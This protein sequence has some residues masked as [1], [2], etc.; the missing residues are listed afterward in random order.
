MAPLLERLHS[1]T[2]ATAE[3]VLGE[4]SGI[5]TANLAKYYKKTV[6]RKKEFWVLKDLDELTEGQQR[7]IMEFKPGEY[8]KLHSKD[9][10]LDK[11]AKHFKLYTDLEAGTANFNLMPVLRISGKEVIFEVGK[12]APQPKQRN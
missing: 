4:L 1:Q 10:A 7:C 3:C 5:A 9:G 8:L 11:L 6:K 2:L 12:P